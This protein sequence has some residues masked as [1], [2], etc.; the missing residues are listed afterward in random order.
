MRLPQPR[1]CV[2]EFPDGSPD[3]RQHQRWLEQ[4]PNLPVQ[5]LEGCE[6]ILKNSYIKLKTA[7]TAI[8]QG[9][10]KAKKESRKTFIHVSLRSLVKLTSYFD[11]SK[12][13][14]PAGNCN[15]KQSRN[16]HEG[17]CKRQKSAK[18]KKFFRKS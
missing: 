1:P 7:M 17:C 11:L 16:R 8:K 5:E 15:D 14:E 12:K 9:A 3:L 13:E 10:T 6:D 4:K 2:R 18:S